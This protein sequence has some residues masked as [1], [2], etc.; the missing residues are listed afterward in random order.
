[1]KQASVSK[2]MC[3]MKLVLLLVLLLCS[4]RMALATYIYEQEPNNTP[5]TAQNVDGYFS[6]EADPYIDF[7][8]STFSPHVSIISTGD[9]TFDFYRFTSTGAFIVLDIDFTNIDPRNDTEI[10]IWNT[11]G[12]L[13]GSND[14]HHLDIGSVED[15]GAITIPFFFQ[16]T[17]DS[18]LL[19]QQPGPLEVFTVGVCRY[20][21]FFAD[22]FSMTFEGIGVQRPGDFYTL[23]I[24]ARAVPE[25]SSLFLFGSGIV[26]F[27]VARRSWNA[28]TPDTYCKICRSRSRIVYQQEVPGTGRTEA[29]ASFDGT[30]RAS[31]R[32]SG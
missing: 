6:S 2:G 22:D 31:Q 3:V 17:F 28:I 15:P 4:P 11:A 1:M 32:S 24:T 10:G 13:I 19:I 9:G 18:W 14:D 5:S 20:E 27:L 30:F 25:P 29:T 12:Q 16:R 21:C 26:G 8:G 7:S 23:H